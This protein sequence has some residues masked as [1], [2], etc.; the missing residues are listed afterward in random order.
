MNTHTIIRNI[1]VISAAFLLPTAAYAAKPVPQDNTTLGGLSCTT[2]QVAQFDG[3]NWVCATL[4]TALPD[5]D[6]LGSLSCGDGQ[7]AEYDGANSVWICATQSTGG[8]TSPLFEVQDSSSTL[9][10]TFVGFSGPNIAQ[11]LIT[12]NSIDYLLEV[13]SEGFMAHPRINVNPD[14]AAGDSRRPVIYYY[15][16]SDCNAATNTAGAVYTNPGNFLPPFGGGFAPALSDSNGYVV[17]LENG[18]A[19]LYTN[20]GGTGSQETFNSV[21]Y[22]GRCF[23]NTTDL[24]YTLDANDFSDLPNDMDLDPL[25]LTTCFDSSTS[26]CTAAGVV[27]LDTPVNLHTNFAPP[28]ILN[29]L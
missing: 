21:R 19:N 16:S 28:F 10:G 15:A 24:L 7:I 23:N 13:N 27:Q 22:M 4:P 11:V 18:A 2:D 1:C 26:S 9:V 8:G 6:T 25:F 3:A 5:E 14:Y 12:Q 17:V 20:P 29:K